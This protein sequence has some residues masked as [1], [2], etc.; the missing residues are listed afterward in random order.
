MITAVA[1]TYEWQP[2]YG[3]CQN[4]LSITGE[5]SL[6]A[7]ALGYFYAPLILLDQRFIHRSIPFIRDGSF[8]EPFPAPPFKDFHPLRAN[9]WQGRFPYDSVPASGDGNDRP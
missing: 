1:D 2:R 7:D 9:R 3:S 6:R 8:I 4:F 5:T